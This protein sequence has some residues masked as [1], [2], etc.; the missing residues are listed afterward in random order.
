MC[1][2]GNLIWSKLSYLENGI[3]DYFDSFISHCLCC[4]VEICLTSPVVAKFYFLFFSVSI[5]AGSTDSCPTA[6]DRML[7]EGAGLKWRLDASGDLRFCVVGVEGLFIPLTDR[8]LAFCSPIWS[9]TFGILNFWVPSRLLTV[10]GLLV[11]HMFYA[12]YILLVKIK[13]L[14]F[15]I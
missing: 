9:L 14:I 11:H 3:Q 4:E 12:T 6:P 7:G 5:A 1:R 2:S 10:G 13:W 8:F 15:G